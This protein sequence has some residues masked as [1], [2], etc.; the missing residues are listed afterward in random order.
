MARE[1]LAMYQRLFPDGHPDVAT[2][3]TNVGRWLTD[4]GDYDNAESMLLE[5]LEMRRQL[6]GD[7]HPR[8]AVTLTGL[9]PIVSGHRALRRRCSNIPRRAA[10]P[11]RRAV[12]GALA[13]RLGGQYR[14]SV[15]DAAGQILTSRILVIAEL[16]DYRGSSRRPSRTRGVDPPVPR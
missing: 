8:V 14:R 13:Y 9:G 6:L 2:G 5:S 12:R 1:S 7:D 4:Q 10:A 16:Q 11:D 15:A 3:L